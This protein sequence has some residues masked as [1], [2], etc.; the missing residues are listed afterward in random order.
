[1]PPRPS[2]R[3]VILLYHRVAVAERDP[4]EMCVPPEVF[5]FQMQY[6]KDRCRPLPLEAV[7][8]AAAAGSIPNRA[9]AVTLDDAYHDNLTDASPVLVNAGVPATFFATTARLDDGHEFWWDTL[10]RLVLGEPSLP[11]V[12]RFD[13]DGLAYHTNTTGPDRVAL[14][15]SIHDRVRVL[16]KGQRDEV[17]R[18]VINQ[19]DKGTTRVAARPMTGDELCATALLPGQDV[20]AHTHEHLSLP[21]Q[22]DDV[23]LEECRASKMRLEKLLNRPVRSLAYPFGEATEMTAKLAAQAGF[24]IGVTTEVGAVTPASETMRLPRF[25]APASRRV[26]VD[27]LERLFTVDAGLVGA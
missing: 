16:P 20:G 15:R 24:T 5:D 23:A 1:M 27:S 14:L 19:I 9:V 11:A 10:T 7:V 13:R 18:Q 21:A 4:F 25:Q 3:A 22:T 17:V 2:G 26:F 12:L 8:H 6:I